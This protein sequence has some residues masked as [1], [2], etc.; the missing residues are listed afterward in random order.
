MSITVSKTREVLVDVARQLF[1]RLGFDNTTMNDIAQA[2][3]KGRRTLYTYFKNKDEVF[4][5]VV[6][7]EMEQLYQILLNLVNGDMPADEKLISFL[8]TRLETI[9]IIVSRNGTLRA[10]FFRDMWQVENARKKYNKQEL[11]LIKKIL[12]DGVEEG[13]FE[14][15]D[16]DAIA[17]IF[18]QALKGLDS[19]YIRG[20]MGH[21]EADRSK[22]LT[23]IMNLIF[24]GIKKK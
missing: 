18:H 23:N 10:A 14:I 4:S 24:N 13:V 9:K 8:Y 19:P 20:K 21:S 2:S 16:I 15:P 17:Y 3:R 7:L 11:G 6:E 22:Q 1:A 5:A 12:H